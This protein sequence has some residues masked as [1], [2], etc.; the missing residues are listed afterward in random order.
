MEFGNKKLKKRENNRIK[1]R[2]RKKENK[3]KIKLLPIKILNKEFRFP[4]TQKKERKMKRNI[5]RKKE[6]KKET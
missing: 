1:E 4:Q 2:Q 5:E 6:R 3:E